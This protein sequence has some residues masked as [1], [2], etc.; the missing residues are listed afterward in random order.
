[1]RCVWHRESILESVEPS[2]VSQN[3]SAQEEEASYSIQAVFESCSMRYV[4]TGHQ[5]SDMGI[6]RTSRDLHNNP[7]VARLFDLE[8]NLR[9]SILD[10]E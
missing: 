9:H 8:R 4:L 1:M 6:F 10:V 3:K 7:L 5:I 2:P